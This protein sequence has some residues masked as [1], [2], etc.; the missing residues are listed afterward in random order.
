MRSAATSPF[1][2]ELIE[3]QEEEQQLD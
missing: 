1:I 3:D 2:W